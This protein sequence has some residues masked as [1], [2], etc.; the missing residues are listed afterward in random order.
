MPQYFLS[1]YTQKVY[2]GFPENYTVLW[3]S[4]C[5]EYLTNRTVEINTIDLKSYNSPAEGLKVYPISQSKYLECSQNTAANAFCLD[6]ARRKILTTSLLQT[7]NLTSG[8]VVI[9]KFALNYGFAN[10]FKFELRLLMQNQCE[11]MDSYMEESERMC[12]PDYF[13]ISKDYTV[14][15]VRFKIPHIHLHKPIRLHRLL[16]NSTKNRPF[17]LRL[18]E[19]RRE[20]YSKSFITNQSRIV[21]PLHI[22]IPN[23]R[24]YYSLVISDIDRQR[25]Y[26]TTSWVTLRYYLQEEHCRKGYCLNKLFHYRETLRNN[27]CPQKELT[28]RHFKKLENCLGNLSFILS[29]AC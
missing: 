7:S 6:I 17:I 12:K 14:D 16:V 22:R 4:E 5:I 19:G 11:A 13:A 3:L 2:V 28:R 24:E 29:R 20:I 15:S 8:D 25:S 10:T 23:A 9:L 1:S 27:H 18:F 21:E 26:A